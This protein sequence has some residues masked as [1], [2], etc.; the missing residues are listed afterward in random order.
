MIGII[1]AMP[2]EIAGIK[3]LLKNPKDQTFGPINFIVGTLRGKKVAAAYCGVGKVFAA[4]CAQTM[5]YKYKPSFIINVGV[6]GG[7]CDDLDAGDIVIA[8]SCLQHDMDTSAVGDLPGLISGIN[9]INI[10]TSAEETALLEASAQEL[11]LR[12]K[13]GI[14]ATG[15]QFINATAKRRELAGKFHAV[16]CDMEGAAIAQVCLVN[17]V[18][19]ALLRAISDNVSGKA[20]IDFKKFLKIAVA[21]SVKVIDLFFTKL[22]K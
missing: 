8:E 4:M 6:A 14:I 16:A 20:H 19:F 12:S 9:I 17:K 13:K 3:K 11:K 18:K 10:F 21:N 5:I 22:Q 2:V 1:S 7:L 15:D